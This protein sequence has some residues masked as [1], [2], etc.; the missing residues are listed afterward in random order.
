MPPEYSSSGRLIHLIVAMLVFTLA[1]QFAA[2]WY[3]SSLLPTPSAVFAEIQR[4][5]AS[6]ELQHHVLIT[7]RRVVISF[8]LAMLI[9]SLIG[10]LMGLYPLLDRILDPYL[11][12]FLNI[13]ALVLI[14]L[15]Y[16]WFGLVE[17]AAITAVVMNKI[18]NAVVTLREGTRTLD[19]SF[20][21]MAKVFEISRWKRLRHII[22][23]Q[24][25]PYFLVAA[26]S[27]LALIWKI[28]LV[29]ELLGRSDGVGFQLHLA[30]QMF[31][32]A[33]ILAYSFTFIL[34]VQAIE[35]GILQPLERRSSRWRRYAEPV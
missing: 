18:P 17:A 22:L 16:V 24:L 21:E 28:V 33:Q 32:I 29:V 12:L 3:Q 5:W 8:V 35:W 9:G 4:A 34:I 27:G 19:P 15:L 7:L 10:I 2:D 14:I 1:W 23:P 26:R 13:P 20:Q 11:V 30:F 31:D 6:G 25:M